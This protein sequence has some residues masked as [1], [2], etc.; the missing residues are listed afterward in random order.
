MAIE[1]TMD[2]Q[3][4]GGLVFCDTTR[5]QNLNYSS[6]F[7]G[8]MKRSASELKLEELLGRIMAPETGENENWSN[9]Q[10]ARKSGETDG[11]SGAQVQDNSFNDVYATAG[12]LGFGSRDR[13]TVND[14][15]SYG[16]LTE[17]GFRAQNLT[18]K[19][20]NISATMDS[21]SSVCGT[22]SAGSP[23]SAN[24]PKSVDTQGRGAA[25]GSS[26]EQSDEDDIEIEAGSCE[27]SN[28]ITDSK[29]LRRIVSNR[30]SARRSREKKQA[31]LAQLELQ[32]DQLRGQ[33]ATLYK[34]F[35]DA[36][37]QFKEA[38]TDNRVLKS[39]IEA[40]RLK[41]RLAEDIVTRGSL[42]CSLNYLLQS[43]SNSPQ[44]LNTNQLFRASEVLASM[45]NQGQDTAYGE[46]AALGS[47]N[48][49]TDGSIKNRLNWNQ[50]PCQRMTSLEHLQSKIDSDH[51]SCMAEFWP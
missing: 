45:D 31:H 7:G 3:T 49:D 48:G 46:I 18:P 1:H 14:L 43:H 12:D 44:L 30:L 20:S 11:F 23:A 16:G 39:D 34:K 4:F 9:I 22:A 2:Q 19:H 42:T 10:R 33:N 28:S 41:V 51:L 13:D 5:P 29:R 40:L 21:Q 15:I 38:A 17:S 27:Q 32:V 24:Q 6:V 25:S 36:S 8:N 35:N 50:P 47:G 37:Q 26:Q